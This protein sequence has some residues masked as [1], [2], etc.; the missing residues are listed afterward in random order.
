MSS[1]Q[2]RERKAVGAP[3]GPETLSIAVLLRCL[4][5]ATQDI[6]LFCD[7]VRAAAMPRAVPRTLGR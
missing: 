2:P 1:K 3:A 6:W 4:R 7:F 5:D